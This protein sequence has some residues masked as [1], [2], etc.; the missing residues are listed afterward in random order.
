MN[1][2]CLV[3]GALYDGVKTVWSTVA[4]TIKLPISGDLQL[5]APMFIIQLCLHFGPGQPNDWIYESFLNPVERC[6]G[7]C[8]HVHLVQEFNCLT[9]SESS[10]HGIGADFDV[11]RAGPILNWNKFSLKVNRTVLIRSIQATGI[12]QI[13]ITVVTLSSALFFLI[14][15]ILLILF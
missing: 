5:L 9:H 10:Q 4:R 3:S 7:T 13:R 2:T 12:Y 14:K 1:E 15:L 11:Y 6:S 8:C